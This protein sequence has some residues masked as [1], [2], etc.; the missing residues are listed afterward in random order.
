MS[1]RHPNK[2]GPS[3]RRKRDQAH[4]PATATNAKNSDHV[5]THVNIAALKKQLSAQQ[6]LQTASFEDGQKILRDITRKSDHLI[7]MWVKAGENEED[8]ITGGEATVAKW[9]TYWSNPTGMLKK[10]PHAI[11]RTVARTEAYLR[12]LE[13]SDLPSARELEDPFSGEHFAK[14]LRKVISK[15]NANGCPGM[16]GIH[17]SWI[18]RGGDAVISALA[19]YLRLVWQSGTVPDTFRRMLIKPLYKRKG[20]HSDPTKYRPIALL[21]APMKVYEALLEIR[22]RKYLEKIDVLSPGQ[23][24]ARAGRRT[25]ENELILRD[26]TRCRAGPTAIAWLDAVK[27]FDSVDR[28]VLFTQMRALGVGGRF[29]SAIVALHTNTRAR[30]IINGK[31]TREFTIINGCK[32]GSVL[33]P[34]LFLLYISPIMATAESSKHGVRLKTPHRPEWRLTILG[35]VD[36]LVL[37]SPTGASLQLLFDTLRDLASDWNTTINASKSAALLTRA[38]PNA[39]AHP[40]INTQKREC[41]S[42]IK[43]QPAHDTQE[44]TIGWKPKVKYLCMTYAG[45]NL[46][47]WEPHISNKTAAMLGSLYRMMAANV[48]GPKMPMQRNLDLWKAHALP[49]LETDCAAWGLDAMETPPL[50][51]MVSTALYKGALAITGL[52]HRASSR[53]LLAELGVARPKTMLLTHLLRLLHTVKRTNAEALWIQILQWAANQAPNLSVQGTMRTLHR[54]LKAERV[55]T[56]DWEP[57][58][59]K[60]KT[61]WRKNFQDDELLKHMLQDTNESLLRA[62]TD[63]KAEGRPLITQPPPQRGREVQRPAWHLT[64]LG[65]KQTTQIL[66]TRILQLRA[67]CGAA[68]K[69]P[70]CESATKTDMVEHLLFRCFPSRNEGPLWWKMKTDML[71]LPHI[72]TRVARTM[73]AWIAQGRHHPARATQALVYPHLLGLSLPAQK[74]VLRTLTEAL[75]KAGLYKQCKGA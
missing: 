33:S 53:V 40:K 24:G 11:K 48:V 10:A 28:H 57:H 47:D 15:L 55:H 34:L 75:H 6:R 17:P 39:A 18:K 66:R 32:Q 19:A 13:M 45:P 21:D 69:C 65:Y 36:D 73:V 38:K 61:S 25:M 41:D 59:K 20:S 12:K 63:R 70:R 43:G 64:A 42:D 52:S 68:H 8:W 60:S 4:V 50:L 49:V 14:D 26:A 1:K 5:D 22:L 37:F 16:D 3:K 9:C 51:K 56:R 74:E 7:P 44:A 54:V 31:L 67:G 72:T 35:F 23:A 71:Q 62:N 29:M 27:A 58:V 2:D 46:N 30:L